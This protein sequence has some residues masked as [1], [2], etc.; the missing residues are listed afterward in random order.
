[1]VHRSA[2]RL[3][4]VIILALA[5]LAVLLVGMVATGRVG[6]V[7]TNGVSMNPLYYQGD[8]AVVT[9][10]DSYQVGQIVAYPIPSKGFVV[11]H[12][13][14]GGNADGFVMKGDNN[15]SID[16][17]HP[18][19]AQLV[20]RAVLRLPQAGLWL[21]QVASPAGLGLIAFALL[22]SGGPAV[23][24]RPLRR[25]ATMSRFAKERPS[26]PWTVALATAPPWLQTAGAAATA[27][28]VL[29][30]ALG[31][32]TWT[33]PFTMV[34]ASQGPT[35][36]S[37]TF[38]YT[39][40]VPHSPAY[41]GTTV[42]S[43]DPVFR[44]LAN[45]VD[46][47]LDYRGSP[48]SVT[49]SAELS[50]GSGWHS[51]V[52]LAAPKTFTTTRYHGTVRLDLTAL[53]A[54]AQAAAA[55]D[56]LPSDQLTVAVLARV[57][58]AGGVRFAPTLPLSLS[59]LQLTLAGGAPTLIVKDSTVVRRATTASRTIDALGA[60]IT[61]ASART[62][63][64]ILLLAGLM[65]AAVLALSAGRSAPKSEAAGIRRR[66]AGL[67]IA[68]QPMSAP[69]GRPVVDVTEFAALARLAERYG[70]LVLHWSRGNVQTFA[71]QDDGTTYRYR[72]SAGD[73]S[74]PITA[75]APADCVPDRAGA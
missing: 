13:I 14:V 18:A 48:G 24:T 47:H 22:A 41:D 37:M 51:T 2:R 53:A 58:T 6:Y 33:G 59:P 63:S 28:A 8:M 10:A 30:L 20:G 21:H 7:I 19:A 11:L 32:L 64:M 75:G 36:R 12:R 55:A 56:G 43:P 74:D 66:Y 72:T 45:T 62:L 29:G 65:G 39:A 26:R 52:P 3:L 17:V 54:R 5:L 70:L 38:S 4:S 67:L 68:V 16:P 71:V 34:A 49:V 31:A 27:V 57:D 61:V 44:K 40:L 25:R 35:T 60:H 15:Q 73:P 50:T 1:M 46:V 42:I 69:P 9:K 23:A